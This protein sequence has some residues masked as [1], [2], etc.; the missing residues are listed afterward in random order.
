MVFS[1]PIFLFY[2][3]PVVLLAYYLLRK[4]IVLQN[5]ILFVSSLLF[6][7]W[8]EKEHSIL[9]LISILINYNVGLLLSK[10]GTQTAQKITLATGII[11]NLSI[12]LYFKYYNF[13]INDFLTYFNL[14]TPLEESDKI[15]LPLGISFFTFHGI[16]YITDIYRREAQVSKNL[17]NVSLYTLFFPQLIAGPIVRYTD[18][19]Q[20]L[21]KREI[22]N[23]QVNSG[24]K[25]FIIGLAKKIIIANSLGRIV[26]AIYTLEIAHLSPALIWFG[27]A[28]FA[29]QL[30][31][32]FSG[33]SDMAIGLAR[34]TGFEFKENFNF[35][36]AARSLT[37]LWTR[38][39]ISLTTFFR[40]YVYIP[41]GGN[42]K[43]A[44]RT[45]S[46]LLF[47]FFLTGLWHGPSWNCI[48]WGLV[49]GFFLVMEKLF[50]RK[51]IEKLPY[52]LANIYTL[53][54]FIIALMIF[55]IDCG[56][57]L[58]DVLSKAFFIH[59]AST[60]I[61]FPSFYLTPDL[62]F[63]LFVAIVFSYPVHQSKV[64]LALHQRIS[65]IPYLNDLMY[66]SLLLLT[67][68]IMS[69]STYNPFIYFKF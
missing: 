24:I 47:V 69:S 55:K 18:I 10:Q 21:V 39:H 23:S 41:L 13:F 29:L 9:V 20:Q 33:Y 22:K 5:L 35:P 27:I 32:D 67:V 43:G 64:Y 45:Y 58:A 6:Y 59:T 40:N 12:L 26:D 44:A 53:L 66:I 19:S 3:L 65:R 14:A 38:W 2:F 50:L 1:S 30:Y 34:M 61:Y 57:H 17:L 16:T 60:K 4:H 31:Y 51:W 15:H 46:N 8:G 36:F 49:T 63:I 25:R 28:V 11:L 7:F 54:L 52:F 37:D 56:E 42:K 48:L 68:C 62:Y